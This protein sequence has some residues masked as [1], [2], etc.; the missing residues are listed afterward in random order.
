MSRMPGT[1]NKN[2]YMLCREAARL[3]RKAAAEQLEYISADR[4]YRIE[5]GMLPSPEEVLKMAKC[6]HDPTLCNYYCANECQIGQ[7]YVPEVRTKDLSQ[8]TLEM[9]ARLNS[10]EREKDRLIEI[11]ADGVISEDEIPDFYVIQDS[12]EKMS[13]SISALRLWVDQR[14]AEG[15][16]ESNHS[17]VP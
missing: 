13:L 2:I 17:I 6:Y 5:K 14:V 3:S 16:L 4:L 12:L 9:L 15:K 1:K 7:E 10:L 8:I 11:C